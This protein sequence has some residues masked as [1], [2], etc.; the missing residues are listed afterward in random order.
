MPPNKC[1][2]EKKLKDLYA[3]I[4]LP[5]SPFTYFLKYELAVL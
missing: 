1:C 2:T 4:L 5:P 3:I